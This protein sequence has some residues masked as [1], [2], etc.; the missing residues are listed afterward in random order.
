MRQTGIL[1]I[2]FISFVIKHYNHVHFVGAHD[3]DALYLHE[4][5]SFPPF[6]IKLMF[7][8]EMSQTWILIVI[9]I[10][11]L[12]S[13]AIMSSTLGYTILMF[14]FSRKAFLSTICLKINVH[15]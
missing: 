10:L 6:F 12:T 9:S 13:T 3:I 15:P 7:I 4:K 5:P 11:F 8:Q 1:I 2:I 14:G